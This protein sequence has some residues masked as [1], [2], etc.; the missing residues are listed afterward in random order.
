MILHQ[1][2]SSLISWWRNSL[3]R[4]FDVIAS[5]LGMIVLSPFFLPVAFLLRRE[6][7]GPIFYHGPRA[8]RGGKPFSI[9]KFRTMHECPESYNGPRVT[10]KDD[11]RITPMGKWLRDTKLNELP[12][13]WNVLIGDMSLVGPR[14]E[15]PEIAKT[16]PQEVQNEILSVRPGITSPASV[17]YRDEESLLPADGV[18]DVYFRDILPDKMRLDRLY[19][20]NHSFMG[21]LDIL[22]WTATS[23]LPRIAR[24]RIPENKLFAGP[25]YRFVQRHVSWFVLDLVICMAAVTLSGIISRLSAPIDWGL[26]PLLAL[27]AILAVLFST[28]NVFLGLDRIIWSRAGAEDGLV[29][30]FS[31]GISVGIL[32]L[33]NSLQEQQPWMSLPALPPEMIVLIGVFT[34]LGNLFARYR[35]RLVTLIANRWLSWRKQPGGFGERLLILGAGEGG[36]IVNWLLRRGKLRQAFHIVGMVDDD[37]TKHGMRIDGCRVLGGSSDLS[38]LVRKHDI[39]VILFAI[40]NL[41]EDDRLSLLKLCQIPGVRLVFMSDI[42]G[43]IQTQLAG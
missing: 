18:M 21:D 16:W 1:R 10:A 9:L 36:Q 15:D 6:S 4:A 3:K 31:N 12:Q 5:L 7:P 14:P 11:N 38:D 27:A 8:G 30:L 26:L 19:V 42:L 17:L 37:L 41:Q 13:L 20:H 43:M 29:L 28:V 24:Q 33:V 35:M 22:F 39:G 34:L 2:S 25:L 23:L 32:L 40:S